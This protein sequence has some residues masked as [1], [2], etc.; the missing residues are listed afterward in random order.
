MRS[1]VLGTSGTA[2][3]ASHGG[4]VNDL[5]LLAVAVLLIVLGAALVRVGFRR[6]KTI[7]EL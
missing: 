7:D 3:A 2:L 5:W 4:S 6:G 1:A